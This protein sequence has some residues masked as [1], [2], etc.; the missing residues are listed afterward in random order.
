MH[1][2]D[3]DGLDDSLGAPAA[4]K[5]GLG[6]LARAAARGFAARFGAAPRWL[7]AAPGRVNLI[8]EHTDYNAGF[9]LPMAIDR[10]TVIAGGPAASAARPV[11]RFHSAALDASSDVPLD[12]TPQA[13]EPTWANYVRGVVAQFQRRGIT[14]AALD[15]F[16]VSDVPLG[17]GLSSSASLEVSTAT[18]LE[19]AAGTT[20]DRLE[21][22]RMC[23]QA[24]H[25]Y[26]HVPCG[27]MD[28]LTAVLGDEYGP[29]L[30]D[31]EAEEA[32][33]VPL[34]DPAVTVL[35]CNS[36]VPHALHDGEYARRRAGCEEAVRVL[37]AWT[38]PGPPA[39]S[40][41]GGF[42]NP[43]RVPML[44][45]PSLRHATLEAV[46][47]AKNALGSEVYRRARHIVTENARTVAAAAALANGELSKFGALMY[48]SHQS[49]RDDFEVSCPE[50]DALVEIAG[51]IGEAGGVFGAR[52]TGG[53]FG[54][55]TVML[56][57]SDRVA[58]ITET[59]AREYRRRQGRAVTTFVSRPGRGAHLIATV[60]SV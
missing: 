35:I 52:M 46:E 47:A 33:L 45:I 48:Q 21:K 53:G 49:L 13:G 38:E 20:L 24:E 1:I 5:S 17:S 43:P 23:R 60:D 44:K 57:R 14:P 6:G 28:Q 34:R 39:Q 50:L 9:S 30:V 29:L 31:F 3:E 22:A 36:N 26:A 58:P 8:G 55:C 41:A 19:A 18:L 15:A 12:Q 51:E 56:V 54:G 37:N 27:L 42:G 25:E 4:E 32:R 16:A 11:L 40:V 7:A 10:Y 59:L 2:A